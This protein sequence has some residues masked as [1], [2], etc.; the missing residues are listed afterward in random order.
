MA[1]NTTGVLVRTLTGQFVGTKLYDTGGTNVASVSAAGALKVDGSAVTQPVSGTVAIGTSV[2]PGTGA[3]NLGKAEDAGHTTGDVGVMVLGVRNDAGTA[4]ATTDLDYIPLSMDA[5]GALRVTGGGGGTQYVG[6]AGATATP[7]GT[8][9][10]GL[11]NSAAPTDVSANNDAVA[12]WML[13]NGSPVMNLAAGGTLILGGN[14]TAA[15]AIRVTMASDSTG[16]I[17]LTGSLPAG[18]NN[19]GDVDVLTVPAPLS[20][21]GNGTAATALRV[22][23]ASDSTGVIAITG[24]VT[25]AAGTNTN[26]VVGDVAQD[27]AIAGNP[28]SMGGRASSA[29]PT[30]MAADGR[31]VYLWL[32][33]S[34]G[35]IVNGRDVHD[36]ALDT[37]T[38]PILIGARASAAAPT[39]V[40]ADGDAVR[41]WSLRN[42]SPVFNLASGGTLITIGQKTMA[43]ALSVS[44]ASDQ[45]AV[46]SNI[47]QVSGATQ[48]ATNP[49]FVRLTDGSAAYSAGSTAPTSPQVSTQTSAAL[50][51][52][53]SAT[54]NHYVTSGKTGRLAGVD[55][56]ATVPCKVVVSTVV[57][58]TPTT[59]FILFTKPFE[60]YQWRSPYP[61]YI[62][63]ASADATSGF[64]AV[65]TNLDET[66]AADVYST[67]YF[68]EV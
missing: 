6:D 38:N 52:G 25:L 65:I 66:V 58:G 48:S 18:T 34:G 3:T 33:R 60:V 39:D 17:T 28:L 54:L 27:V 22:T 24:N 20:T 30:A 47:T 13:R 1:D 8:I 63:R 64:R 37:N 49:L 10:M 43:N 5:N 61:T 16:V 35:T 31:S 11:A 44:I 45:S 2:V 67:A 14:G 7:T 21:T 53:A 12:M 26:E 68:D 56:G 42:G 36:A 15:G 55:V 4:L 29:V 9:A 40:S 23:M 62:T 19:I 57:T 41:L 46:A 50:G 32:D 51:A 59:R